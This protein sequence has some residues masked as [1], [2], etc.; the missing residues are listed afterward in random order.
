[1]SIATAGDDRAECPSEEA[2]VRLER[3][4]AERVPCGRREAQ[5]LIRRGRVRLDGIVERSPAAQVPAGA[6]VTLDDRVLEAAPLLVAYHKPVGVQCTVGDPLDRPNLRDTV[7]DW[8]ALGLHPV[9]RLD[10]DSEG[11]LLLCSDGALT[12]RLL[13]PKHGVRKIYEATVDGEP[14]ADLGALLA[15]GVETSIGV[16]PAE[17]VG[18]E[19]HKVTLAVTEGKHRMVRR[20][21]NNLGL[22]VV[23]LV[24][25]QFGE[26]RLLDLEPGAVRVLA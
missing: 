22:P 2:R 16:F 17:L 19:G 6:A 9:G 18:I 5:A 21:L 14:P 7:G 23:R 12:Q 3:L 25:L 10:A 26:H 24:R 15:A 11:L 1:M 20:I 8:L 13:H 4:V